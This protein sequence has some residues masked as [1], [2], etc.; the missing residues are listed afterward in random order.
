MKNLR[1]KI[2]NIAK[3]KNMSFLLDT[4]GTTECWVAGI[5]D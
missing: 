1:K 2:M 3:I 4:Q 5:Y